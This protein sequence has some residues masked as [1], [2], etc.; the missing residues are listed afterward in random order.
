M[1]QRSRIATSAAGP[2]PAVPFVCA[3]PINDRAQSRQTPRRK[4]HIDQK[5]AK[6]PL[7][8]PLK[9]P[10]HARDRA[11]PKQ[12]HPSN[13]HRHR[14]STKPNPAISRLSA[15][16]TP[17]NA[18]RH[19]NAARGVRETYTQA[20]VRR[21]FSRCGAASPKQ[22]FKLAAAFVGIDDCSAERL[23]ENS[24]FFMISRCSFSGVANLMV[25]LDQSVP[26][27]GNFRHL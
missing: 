22:T 15:S 13:P 21:G 1:R 20:A 10:R 25:Q 16:P 23:C 27:S 14:C 18:P 7:R 4:T 17:G 11:D 8:S 9:A 5:H 19:P 2:P 24:G 6:R 3:T 26:K 12:P